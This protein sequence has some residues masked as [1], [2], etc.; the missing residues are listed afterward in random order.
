MVA[1]AVLLVNSDPVYAVCIILAANRG[2]DAERLG[3]ERGYQ[4]FRKR[5]SRFYTERNS[6]SLQF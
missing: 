2:E 3:N 4:D 5:R 6:L 1:C